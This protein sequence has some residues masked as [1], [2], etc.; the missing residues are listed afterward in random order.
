M[1]KKYNCEING[2]KYHRKTKTIGHDIDGKPIKKQFYGSGEKDATRKLEEYTNKIR[3]GLNLNYEKIT[4]AQLMFEW[5][6]NVL[7]VSRQDKSS[8]FEKHETNYRI[9]IKD[10]D[11]G[12]LTVFD[13]TPKAIQ[14]YY[15]DLYE[16]G[17]DYLDDEGKKVHKKVSSEKIFDINKTLRLFFTYCI[18]SGCQKTNPCSLKKIKIPGNSDGDEMEDDD[19]IWNEDIQVF[20]DDELELIKEN[21]KY[22]NGKDNTF[23]VAIQLDLVTGLRKGELLGLKKKFVNLKLCKVKVRWTLK[24]VKVFDSPKQYHRELKLIDPKSVT[25]KRIVDFPKALV[26]ILELYFKE[27][28]EKY[29][30]NGLEFNEDSLIFTTASCNPIDA[31]N[32]SRAWERFLK[33]IKVDFKKIHAIRDTFATFLIRRGA[34]IHNVKELL[35]HSSISITEKYYIFVFPEDKSETVNLLSDFIV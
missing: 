35:G 2:V 1:A 34:K 13:V 33:R 10:S 28:E 22:Q 16:D 6:F 4:V 21:I 3:D 18:E 25:S 26:P 9:Y 8:S 14:S 27:Q 24:L 20:N 5:L 30:K 11:I 19:D 31:S 15:N 23:N 32:F 17:I 7:Y 29:K 12:Y